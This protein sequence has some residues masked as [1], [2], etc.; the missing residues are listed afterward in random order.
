MERESFCDGFAPC[1]IMDEFKIGVLNYRIN[2]REINRQDIFDFR[3]VLIYNT[4]HNRSITPSVSRSSHKTPHNVWKQHGCTEK[5][6]RL[7]RG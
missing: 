4:K 5:L 3:V 1:Q 6:S 2:R 7:N